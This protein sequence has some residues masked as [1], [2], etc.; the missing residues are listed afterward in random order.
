LSDSTI[1]QSVLNTAYVTK[2]LNEVSKE[3]NLK[4]N[5]DVT[6]SP[7]PNPRIGLEDVLRVDHLSQIHPSNLNCIMPCDQ[8]YNQSYTNVND[9]EYLQSFLNE[10]YC[11]CVCNE[12]EV[13]VTNGQENSKIL[14]EKDIKVIQ[15]LSK[16]H[17]TE[18]TK[19][20]KQLIKHFEN[21]SDDLQTL[22]EAKLKS[23]KL[24][25]EAL[26]NS[27]GS[28]FRGVSVNGKSWQVFIVINKVKC[29]AGCVNTQ[30]EAASL[31]DK[32]AI[33]FHGLKV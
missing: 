19:C 33:V 11:V 29:Y 28:K 25:P 3:L 26:R 27:R 23:C 2:S 16:K 18:R 24:S 32:L 7:D 20:Y 1:L 6:G 14:S 22:F 12:K 30:I 21:F 17:A 8:L 4:A 15:K 9:L 10:K 5:H 31:Y 13:P